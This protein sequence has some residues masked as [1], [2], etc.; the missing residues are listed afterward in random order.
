MKFAIVSAVLGLAALGTS[1]AQIPFIAGKEPWSGGEEMSILAHPS[2]P[3][4]KLRVTRPPPDLC[5]RSEQSRSWAGYLDVDLDRL[6]EH[7]EVHGLDTLSAAEK[8][9]FGQ[10][11][12]GV[13]EHFYFWAFESRN[14]PAADPVMLWLNGGPGCSS[15]TGLLMELGPCSVAP[16]NSS[17]G[18]HTVWNKWA[19]NNNATVVFLDQPVGVGYSYSSWA[20]PAEHEAHEFP[21]ARI[22]DAPSAARDASAFL[23]LLAL[24][25]GDV[26][27][28]PEKGLAPI[29]MAGESYG[30]RYLPLTA[31]Q[32]LRDN[33]E[34]AKHPERG[35]QPL[36]LASVLIGNGFTSPV[37]Q[38]P[39]YVEFACG[40]AHGYGTFLPK[41]QCDSMNEDIPTCLALVE[42]CNAAAGPSEDYDV[43]ACKLAMDY[44]EEKLA[45]PWDSTGRS[46]YDWRHLGEYEEDGW[47][48]AFLNA[49][50]TKR[51]LGVDAASGDK[52]DGKF[53]GCS[54]AVFKHFGKTGDGARDS[55][56]AVKDILAKGVRVLTYYGAADF[57]CNY[58]GGERWTL[59]MDW[60]GKDE[61]RKQPLTDWFEPVDPRDE[62]SS[63]RRG[64]SYRSW[65]NF[66]YATVEA[67]GHFAPHDRP[68]A[69]LAM[70]NYWLHG[71]KPGHL[72]P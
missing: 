15:F 50:G 39:A 30:G 63:P 54:D 32:L 59:D 7:A 36:P 2:L 9:R 18:P 1:G 14:D 58:L 67:S 6:W 3:A 66:T 28:H 57:I 61:F 45:A 17:Q 12:K 55:V 5:E 25:A 70:A 69:A 37:V 48:A 19:W 44:C 64:G 60:D 13:V 62:Q 56:W 40:N 68:R 16:S 42:K 34:A 26:F 4:H 41:E 31:S 43:L 51:A 52:H 71:S 22:Y 24:H 27:G 47:I 21:P 35:L 10:R 53:V 11:P 65:A 38:Y 33:A 72:E 46:P 29:S 49:N 8:V 20:N 23:H